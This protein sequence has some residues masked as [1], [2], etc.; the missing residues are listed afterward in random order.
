VA[1]T[2]L[3]VNSI[4]EL[5]LHGNMIIFIKQPGADLVSQHRASIHNQTL[6][7]VQKFILPFIK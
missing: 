1:G 5:G 4:P 3:S 6:K 7:T 2:L